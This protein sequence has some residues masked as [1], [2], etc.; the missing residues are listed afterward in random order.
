MRLIHGGAPLERTRNKQVTITPRNFHQDDLIG[1]LEDKNIN[2]VFAIGP[3]G[4]G[5]TI[6]STLQG[7]NETSSLS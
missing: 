3:A 7:I 6:V 5:K 4:T 1:L 2:I